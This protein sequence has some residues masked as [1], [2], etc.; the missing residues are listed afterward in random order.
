M[1]SSGNKQLI[2]ASRTFPSGLNYLVIRCDTALGAINQTLPDDEPG[3]L[4]A[5]FHF[6]VNSLIYIYDQEQE[7]NWNLRKEQRRILI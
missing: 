7:M 6:W 3:Y 1:N 5:S 2:N 4:V